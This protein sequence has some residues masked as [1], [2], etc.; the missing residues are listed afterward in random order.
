MIID[1]FSICR[2]PAIGPKGHG[3]FSLLAA[4]E[5]TFNKLG[6]VTEILPLVLLLYSKDERFNA[7]ISMR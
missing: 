1:K 3:F 5:K 7:S 2:N 6:A 4:F